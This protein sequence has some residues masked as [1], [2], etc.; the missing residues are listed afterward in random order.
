MAEAHATH[1][2]MFECAHAAVLLDE[3]YGD[4]SAWC[5]RCGEIKVYEDVPLFM[6]EG[7]HM[8]EG[9]QEPSLADQVSWY[10][11][12]QLFANP[13]ELLSALYR[14]Y[15]ELEDK[16]KRVLRHPLHDALPDFRAV[17]AAATEGVAAATERINEVVR[18]ANAAFRSGDGVTIAENPTLNKRG[19]PKAPDGPAGAMD[20]RDKFIVVK[21]S[22]W[23]LDFM[24][25][26]NGGVRVVLMWDRGDSSYELVCVEQESS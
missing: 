11:D 8:D 4:G 1:E 17:R 16:L 14:E 21:T 9:Q 24:M 25:P 26:Q 23:D 19:F 6:D 5:Q 22:P 15:R 12:G 7:Q 18:E 2:V 13:T 20:V 3:E 10:L